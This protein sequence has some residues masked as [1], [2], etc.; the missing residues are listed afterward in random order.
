MFH[1]LSAAQWKS[2]KPALLIGLALAALQIGS[3]VAAYYQSKSL[4]WDGKYQTAQNLSRGLV[5]A[6][7]DQM[8]LKDYGSVESRILQTMSN[9]EVASVML[10]DTSGRVLSA[11]RRSPGQEP[12]LLFDPYWIPT[13][14]SD[15]ALLQ[16]RDDAYI[17]TWAKVSLGS[18]LGWVRLQTYNELDSA[19]LGSLREQNFLLSVL[20][21]VSGIIILGVFLWRAYFTVVKREH[22]FEVKLDEAT[23]RLVQSEKL[24][25]LGEL[26]A[27]VAHEINNPVGYVSSNLTTL[28]KYL[29]VY[30]KVLDAPEADSAEMAALKKKLN[31]AF[32]RDDLQ[33]LVKET[34]EGVGRVKAIIQ[35]L[36][37]YARTNVATNY[38]AS[39]IQVGLKST[40]N[41][42]RNQL[43]NRADVRLALGN[44]P[45]V[46]CAPSQIDQVF[47]NLIVNAAQAMP[48]GKMGMI[49]IRTDCND[50]KVW[51]EVQDNGPGIPPDVMKKIFDPFFTTKDPGTGTGLGLSVS[52]NIIQQHGGKL[53]VSSTVGVGTT[54]KITL[55]IKRPAAKGSA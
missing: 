15:Q 3:G 32:I 10:T 4:L 25:S 2:I 20:S 9:V 28:Q 45:L 37:D 16:S 49:D 8:V 6:V 27:G 13:P 39:D 51:I 50:R 22:M 30:E 33:N 38:V 12:R 24:A 17:T 55:P 41:I 46:E 11:L 34:Q 18:D 44:L 54:F 23:K 7:A 53:E 47:L 40:I 5:V 19:N 42:A 14:T 26:A 35:D 21:V 36:K 48:E 52:Q 31:Y 29:A 1:R 43:K